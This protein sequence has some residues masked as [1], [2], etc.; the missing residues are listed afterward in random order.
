MNENQHLLI[1][2]YLEGKSIP[3]IDQFI[4]AGFPSPAEDYLEPSVNLNEYVSDH[5]NATFSIRVSGSSMIDIGICP[6]DLLIVDRALN[7]MNGD[8]V[9]AVLNREFTVKELRKQNQQISLIP[10]NPK[11]KPIQI[12]QD[13]ELEIWGVVTV[14]VRDF[15]KRSVHARNR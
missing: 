11:F 5:P 13:D 10:H 7:A 12:S 14:V 3:V 1:P 4:A 2:V 15:R 8:I 6:G 9:I